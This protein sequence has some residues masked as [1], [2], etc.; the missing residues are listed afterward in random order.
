[1][2]RGVGVG[3]VGGGEANSEQV[4][5]AVG[6]DLFLVEEHRAGLHDRE[7]L[8]EKDEEKNTVAVTHTRLWE[9]CERRGEKR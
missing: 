9:K 3:G 6:T 2:G 1:M 7:R 8:V 5:L 4:T